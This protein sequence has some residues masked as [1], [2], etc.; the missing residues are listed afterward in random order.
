V[1]LTRAALSVGGKAGMRESRFRVWFCIDVSLPPGA[2]GRSRRTAR[3][4]I[5]AVCA[6]AMLGAAPAGAAAMLGAAPAGPGGTVA[7]T[8]TVASGAARSLGEPAAAQDSAV[9]VVVATTFGSAGAQV[10]AWT[11]PA[12]S[13][14]WTAAGLVL[15]AG[16]GSSYDASAAAGPGGPLLVVAGASPAGQA[17][18]TNGSVAL[19][20]VYSSGRLGPVRLISD[21][22]GTGRF[23]DRPAVAVGLDGTVWVA[24]SQGPDA[25][26]CQDVGTGDRVEVAVSHDGGRTFSSP[27][28]MPADGGD[29]A[30]GAR[31]APLGGGR[32]AVSWTESDGPEDQAVLVSVLGPGGQVTRP[33]RVL[34]GDALPLVLPGAS[35]YDF[36]AGDITALP[37]GALVVAAPFWR[38]GRGVIDLA[39]GL[40][41]GQWRSSVIAPPDG[42]DL[43]LPALGATSPAS[44]RLICAV[45]VRAADRLGYDWADLR[46]SGQG[47]ATASAGLAPLTPAPAGPGFFEL[48]EE[49]SVTGSPSGL[50]SSVVVAGRGGAVLQTESWT[51]PRPAITASPS[52]RTPAPVPAPSRTRPGA[53]GAQAGAA[54]SGSVWA[55]LVIAAA[56]VII[57]SAALLAARTA[58]RRGARGTSGPRHRAGPG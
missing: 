8:Q 55:W 54:R 26:A 1:N 22:R 35:F 23:D 49:L 33:Q 41:G 18:I 13:G 12:G 9:S 48:G 19:A 43:L 30:F 25:D 17:C 3:L 44:A 45:H 4:L 47:P 14:S 20:D 34:A 24:W 36:P 15:P 16:F 32:V 51:A 57:V 28:P 38:Y 42:A 46:I 52:A 29:A 50:L 21:Q 31:L 2:V 11:K 40:P 10:R 27:V 56:A 39:V 37:G 53:R 5:A 6:M 58:R 7:V